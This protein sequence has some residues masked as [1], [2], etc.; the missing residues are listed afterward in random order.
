MKHNIY[1]NIYGANQSQLAVDITISTVD[2][3]I[4]T[5][6]PQQYL[7]HIV[8]MVISTDSDSSMQ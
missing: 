8:D 7:H 6:Y 4:S 3:T 2:F 1:D 5:Q